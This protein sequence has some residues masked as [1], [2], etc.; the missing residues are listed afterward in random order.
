[1]CVAH[2]A[3]YVCVSRPPPQQQQ[4]APSI[5]AGSVLQR[6]LNT[7]DWMFDIGR[8]SNR[9]AAAAAAA[10]GVSSTSGSSSLRGSSSQVLV[11]P[12]QVS[13][14][15]APAAAAAA[16]ARLAQVEEATA[17]GAAA[18]AAAATRRASRQG[19][20]AAASGGAA[21]AAGP[22][23]DMWDELG[24][25]EVED[26]AAAA[27]RSRQQRQQRD[28]QLAAV[29][30]HLPPHTAVQQ[31]QQQQ[32]QQQQGV[33]DPRPLSD[34]LE[35][36]LDALLAEFQ[37]QA[38]GPGAYVARG[39]TGPLPQ[40]GSYSAQAAAAAAFGRLDGGGAWASDDFD[41]AVGSDDSGD[42]LPV[43]RVTHVSREAGAPQQQSGAEPEQGGGARTAAAARGGSRGTGRRRDADEGETLPRVAFANALPPVQEDFTLEYSDG[44]PRAW[45]EANRQRRVQQQQQPQPG[46]GGSSA[47][48]QRVPGHDR[49]A[50]ASRATTAVLPA[51]PVAQ[52]QQQPLRVERVAA[53]AAG[54]A[55]QPEHSSS[56][57]FRISTVG[58]RPGIGGSG[59]VDMMDEMFSISRRPSSSS[60]SSN[61]GQEAGGTGSIRHPGM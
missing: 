60:R 54:P 58:R 4:Q 38:S 20:T 48:I 51:A 55:P 61:S 24:K 6:P 26:A 3:A 39:A 46:D 49:A 44:P 9:V 25:A 10:A 53:A 40:F 11:H 27:A 23:A 47:G 35:S 18:A 42:F 33:H 1:V 31:P 7:E 34:A 29:L 21:A 45:M 28:R 57:G 8:S 37:V 12:G 59:P 43:Q 56:S 50:A 30:G 15:D 2:A 36:R 16:A 22:A 17:A 5:A 19:E 14:A 41:A 32:Q 13:A 52:Q